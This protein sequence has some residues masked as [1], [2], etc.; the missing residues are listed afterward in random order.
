MDINPAVKTSS[1]KS[2]LISFLMASAV[3]GGVLVVWRIVAAGADKVPG[4]GSF[5]ARVVRFV[6]GS[7]A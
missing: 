5:V 2:F 6:F 7:A 1:P 4:P 3:V